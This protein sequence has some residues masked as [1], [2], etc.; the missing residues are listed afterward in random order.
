[1][2]EI[3]NLQSENTRL[4]AELTALQA[5]HKIVV[6]TIIKTLGAINLWPIK[7][8][9]NLASKAIKAV[10]RIATD[11]IINPKSLEERFSF[12]QEI[13]PLC[14]KYKDFQIE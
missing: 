10:S 11:A 3:E 12:I 5:E 9:D 8:E 6:K 4:Q 1:M 14:E 13:Y 2:T 7:P